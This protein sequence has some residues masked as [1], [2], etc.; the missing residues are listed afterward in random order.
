VS[1]GLALLAVLV[2][3][4]LNGFFV[5]AEFAL[6]KLRPTQVEALVQQEKPR[7]RLVAHL[8]AN[9]D[10][11]LSV[12]QLGITLASIALGFVGEPA[13]AVLVQPLLGSWAWAHA[14]AIGFAFMTVSFLHVLLGEQ[15]PKLLAIRAPAA[16]A[17]NIAPL[18]RAAHW[19]LWVPLVVMNGSARLV[20]R[21]LGWSA[22][23]HEPVHSED[24]LRVILELSQSAGSLSFR[25]LL[26]ME[27]VFDLRSVHV[28]DAMRLRAGV[29]VLRAS[30]PWA[31]NLAEIRR[32]RQT[33]YP[34]V[35]SDG[36]P[37]GIIHVKDLV[38]AGPETMER[39]DLR[40]LARPFVTVR[41]NASLETL[42][43]DLQRRHRHM[44]IVVDQRDRWTGL[45]TLEDIIEEIVGT[46]EDE[47]VLES[48]MFLA[49]GLTEGRVV[50]GVVASSLEDAIREAFARVPPNELPFPAARLAEAVVERERGMP[51]LLAQGLAAPHARIE[52]LRDFVLIFA[53]SD[54]GIPVHGHEDRAHLLFILL[55]P[56]RDPRVQLRLLARV[57]GL[58]ESEYVV[59]RLRQ[60]ESPAQVLEVLRAADP[61][62]LT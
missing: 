16:S 22:P 27:N 17:L 37:I 45:I 7:A 60:A 3:L 50:L 12:C 20:L 46:I 33:R 58:L 40:A 54:P 44:A 30:A 11:Y 26:L 8:Q 38:L 32:V 28:R 13:F 1:V 29:A 24:E 31:E 52:Q 41:E 57:A 59:D 21:L 2:L 56:T 51:T 23:A 5:L 47:F 48:P 55:T 53:R 61:G 4:M 25:Q 14:V 35:E 49:D 42:L 6:V 43:G 39:P 19:V 15:V 34:L 62:A 9:L 18:L 10:E 36:K